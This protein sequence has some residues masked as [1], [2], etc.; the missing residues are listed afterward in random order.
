VAG[1]YP[2]SSHARAFPSPQPQP[3][4]QPILQAPQRSPVPGG[5]QRPHP[6]VNNH[7][8]WQTLSNNR[9]QWD[10]NT[11][12]PIRPDGESVLMD[13]TLRRDN[14]IYCRVPVQNG[15]CNYTN[16]KKE[17]SLHHMRKDHLAFFPFVCGGSCR[18][19]TWYVVRC[20]R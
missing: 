3:W 10:P 19:P 16:V 20:F 15:H 14:K 9:N 1:Q 2:T 12:E 5:S 13:F 6:S 17:R 8:A 11:P 7:S 18:S 4:T